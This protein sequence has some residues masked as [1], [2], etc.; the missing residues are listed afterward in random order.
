M[1]KILTFYEK[2]NIPP[3]PSLIELHHGKRFIR[4]L[5]TKQI[6]LFDIYEFSVDELDF[7]MMELYIG[8]LVPPFI[9]YHF[10]LPNK[11]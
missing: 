10:R 3:T 2:M 11:T 7:V 4:L 5:G 1:L 6:N 8:S 9:Y